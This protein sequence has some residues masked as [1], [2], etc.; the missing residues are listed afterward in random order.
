MPSAATASNTVRTRAYPAEARPATFRAVS[1]LGLLL[2]DL[3][4]AR[5]R[6]SD[7][8]VPGRRFALLGD[9]YCRYVPSGL[10][11]EAGIWTLANPGSSSEDPSGVLYHTRK[12]PSYLEIPLSSSA[13]PGQIIHSF[14]IPSA[15]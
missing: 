8:S 6:A 4:K 14:P 13:A 7:P 3:N 5:S 2:Q 10:R 9:L 15:R 1:L 11:T 12:Q